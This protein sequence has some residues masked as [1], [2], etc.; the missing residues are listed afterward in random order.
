MKQYP[1]FGG[2]I[3]S[4]LLLLLLFGK[5]TGVGERKVVEELGVGCDEVGDE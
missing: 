1:S 3:R 4:E 2:G 5:N